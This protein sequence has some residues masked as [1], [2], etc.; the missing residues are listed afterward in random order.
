MKVVLNANVAKLGFKGDVVDVK[1]GYYRNVLMPRGLAQIATRAAQDLAAKRREKM[2]VEKEKLLA[3]VKEVVAQLKGLKVEIA[4]KVTGKGT[5]YAALS[6]DA[7]VDAVRAASNIQLE[8]K[9][10]KIPDHI[11]SLGEYTVDIDFGEGNVASVVVKIVK[12]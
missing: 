9:Y 11:K 7:V 8:K 6:Q 10:V 2:V 5:L 3:N 1:D 12:A 4:A